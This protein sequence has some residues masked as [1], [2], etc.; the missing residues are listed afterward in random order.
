MSGQSKDKG[1]I[2]V[3]EMSIAKIIDMGEESCLRQINN[4]EKLID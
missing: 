2:T 4:I 3:L 1:N